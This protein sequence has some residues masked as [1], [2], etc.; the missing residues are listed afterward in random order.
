LSRAGARYSW[1][2]V[3]D[4]YDALFAELTKPSSVDA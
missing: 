4:Q 1:D 3:T 2:R